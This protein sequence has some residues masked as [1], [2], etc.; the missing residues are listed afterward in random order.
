MLQGSQL[1]LFIINEFV[2]INHNKSTNSSN[3]YHLLSNIAIDTMTHTTYTYLLLVAQLIYQNN[4]N[5]TFQN[6]ISLPFVMSYSCIIYCGAPITKL[7]SSLPQI[8]TWKIDKPKHAVQAVNYNFQP[9]Q[10]PK[11]LSKLSAY[12]WTSLCARVCVC[13][14][15]HCV[16]CEIPR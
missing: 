14:M 13:G 9:Y 2:T 6:P 8:K 4:L 16:N 15:H 11:H 1:M 5:W 3:T 7:L 10:L 12:V